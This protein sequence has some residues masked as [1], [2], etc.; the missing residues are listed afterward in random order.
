ETDG[1]QY[2]FDGGYDIHAHPV[3][4]ETCVLYSTPTEAPEI[5]VTLT[6]FGTPIVI[7]AAGGSFDYNIDIGNTGISIAVF[8]VW[9]EVVL[10]DGTVYGP[11]IL[12]NNI[13]LNP[14]GSIIRDMTQTIPGAAPVGDY[15][16]RCNA[17]MYPAAVMASDEFPFEKSGV[18]AS[19]GGEWLL[20][21]WEGPLALESTLPSV[22]ELRQNQPNPFNPETNIEFGLPQAGKVE[23]L[24][25]NLLGRQVAELQNG[26][27]AAGY[28]TVTFDAST[29]SSGVYFYMMKTADHTQVK[30][31][32]LVK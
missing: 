22:Y 15:I 25:F 16:Y 32:L 29:M 10:P 4:N 11:L 19:S 26:F 13:T 18:D 5:A 21:G 28:H 20:D 31:M 14:G 1:L 8:D 24:V 3:E 23:I 9:I 2:F 6:P 30:K 7:P 27:M 17:G 12:R